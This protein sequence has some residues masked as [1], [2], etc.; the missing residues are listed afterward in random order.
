MTTLPEGGW[1]DRPG[2][3]ALIDALGGGETTRAVGG[4]VRDSLLGLPVSDVDLATRLTPD[5]V[6]ARLK[7]AEIKA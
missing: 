7:A 6:I 2:L 4:A 5:D 1:R 3:A